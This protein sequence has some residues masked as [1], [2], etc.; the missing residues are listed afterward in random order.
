MG[1]MSLP[2]TDQPL[3]C[4][5]RRGQR[6]PDTIYPDGCSKPKGVS[7]DPHN[8]LNGASLPG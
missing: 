5:F 1:D 2:K 6:R 8:T 7:I 4:E 3:P